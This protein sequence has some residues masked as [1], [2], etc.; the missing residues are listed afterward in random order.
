MP[1]ELH[2]SLKN[3][4]SGEVEMTMNSGI[5]DLRNHTKYK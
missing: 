3:A 1:K 4:I 2:L 5:P